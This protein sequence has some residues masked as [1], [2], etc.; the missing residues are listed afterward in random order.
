MFYE[1]IE[2]TSSFLLSEACQNIKVPAVAF[3]AK[4]GVGSVNLLCDANGLHSP[5]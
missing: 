5:R 1:H 4:K 2:Q 3:Y